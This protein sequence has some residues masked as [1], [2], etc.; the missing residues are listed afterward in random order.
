MGTA[1][2]IDDRIQILNDWDSIA[3]SKWPLSYRRDERNW[4]LS[5]GK[6]FHAAAHSLK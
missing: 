2:T 3:V 1:F 5:N 4:R 6:R